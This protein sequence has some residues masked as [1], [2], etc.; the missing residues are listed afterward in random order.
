MKFSLSGM[1]SKDPYAW[2]AK[3]KIVM[4]TGFLEDR[5]REKGQTWAFLPW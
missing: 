3:I 2:K 4:T 5:A 1:A